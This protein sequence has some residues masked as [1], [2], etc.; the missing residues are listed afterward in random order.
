MPRLLRIDP[1]AIELLQRHSYNFTTILGEKS[2]IPQLTEVSH[3]AVQLLKQ[4]QIKLKLSHFVTQY[5]CFADLTFLLCPVQIAPTPKQARCSS[6][7][8]RTPNWPKLTAEL[9]RKIKSHDSLNHVTQIVVSLDFLLC[10]KFRQWPLTESALPILVTKFMSVF[11]RHGN[12]FGRAI[13]ER[14]I[15]LSNVARASDREPWTFHF[16]W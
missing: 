5:A 9:E 14:L 8:P 12:Q 15:K 13:G 3:I 7:K 10:V 11:K 2:L 4:Q 1:F 16:R 6:C